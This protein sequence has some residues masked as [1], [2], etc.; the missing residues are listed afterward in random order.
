M[1][2]WPKSLW[3]VAPAGF[4]VFAACLIFTFHRKDIL[5]D[6]RDLRKGH[7]GYCFI[8]SWVCVPLLLISSF[9]YV[10]L[11]KRQWAQKEQKI[12]SWRASLTSVT[13][14]FTESMHEREKNSQN[15]TVPFCCWL[16][17][18]CTVSWDDVCGILLPWWLSVKTRSRQI[19]II[20]TMLSCCKIQKSNWLVT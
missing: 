19:N 9:L 20:T 16:A 4:T 1:R 18:L 5:N 8:L 13:S 12:L 11:R 10:H 7:F 15:A 3:C 2:L 17:Q 14:Q 6:S